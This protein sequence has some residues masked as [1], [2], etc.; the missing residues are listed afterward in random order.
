M[1]RKKKAITVSLETIWEIPDAAWQRLQ[2]IL[3]EAY[4]A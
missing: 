3:A 1:A 2:P 4:P